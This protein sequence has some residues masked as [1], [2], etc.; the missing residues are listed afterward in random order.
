MLDTAIEVV[1]QQKQFSGAAVEE[2]A[3]A[4]KAETKKIVEALKAKKERQNNLPSQ[5]PPTLQEL[6]L[7]SFPHKNSGRRKIT[8][9]EAAIVAK[10]DTA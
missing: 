10:A 2:F 4:F 1:E 5:L 9:K 8:G 7:R 3:R 6:K